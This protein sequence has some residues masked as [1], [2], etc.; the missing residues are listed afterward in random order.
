MMEQERVP[1]KLGPICDLFLETLGQGYEEIEPIIEDLMRLDD[2]YQKEQQPKVLEYQPSSRSFH[3]E[4]WVIQPS[5]TCSYNTLIPILITNARE[6]GVVYLINESFEARKGRMK[7]SLF[8]KD[9]NALTYLSM[10]WDLD[11][12]PIQQDAPVYQHFWLGAED[13]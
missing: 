7:L 9:L 10:D 5:A 6:Y 13:D 2:Y 3:Y 11:E 12:F 4:G 1:Y 8:S